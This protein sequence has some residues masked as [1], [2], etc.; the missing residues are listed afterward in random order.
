MANP[1]A[2]RCLSTL[3]F[4]SFLSGTI[5]GA[6]LQTVEAHLQHCDHCYELYISTLNH[7][8]EQMDREPQNY[9]H[10]TFTGGF[11]FAY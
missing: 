7:Y 5:F 4:A 8:Y 10:P 2:E 6:K 1:S 9:N 3:D 11:G